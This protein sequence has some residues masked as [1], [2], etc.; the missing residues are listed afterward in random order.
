MSIWVERSDEKCTVNEMA[1]VC[2]CNEICDVVLEVV[3]TLV[4]ACGSFNG[5]AIK[6]S[7]D[8]NGGGLISRQRIFQV[9]QGGLEL[10]E[11]LNP[12]DQLN[13]KSTIHRDVV[14]AWVD[15]RGFQIDRGRWV[16]VSLV[17]L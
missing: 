11:V 8:V 6:T 1:I 7:H 12:S 4:L 9:G 14:E 2:F 5:E 10:E 13:S 15:L 17:A 3:F 16:L